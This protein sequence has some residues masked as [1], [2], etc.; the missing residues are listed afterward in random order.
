MKISDEELKKMFEC[1]HRLLGLNGLLEFELDTSEDT[2]NGYS[3]DDENH[4]P[5]ITADIDVVRAY[6]ENEEH[7]L[8]N[9]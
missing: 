1:C 2:I 8:K 7:E 6:V 3:K 5:V 4:I 9:N